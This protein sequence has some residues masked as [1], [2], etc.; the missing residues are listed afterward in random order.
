MWI[1]TEIER[2]KE[3][4]WKHGT[5]VETDSEI[6]MAAETGTGAKAKD[7]EKVATRVAKGTRVNKPQPSFSVCLSV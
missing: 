7:G 6:G 2:E 5:A 1:E 3:N 4:E